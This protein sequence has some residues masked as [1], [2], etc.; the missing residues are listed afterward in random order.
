M[1]FASLA[2]QIP[3]GAS[4]H[5][6]FL[7]VVAS[8]SGHPCNLPKQGSKKPGKTHHPRPVLDFAHK[9]SGLIVEL[10]TDQ[11]SVRFPNLTGQKSYPGGHPGNFLG[12]VPP[13]KGKT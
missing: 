12:P 6:C 3:N 8:A 9:E 13:K 5:S 2:I 4:N 10:L 11:G 7:K 1:I